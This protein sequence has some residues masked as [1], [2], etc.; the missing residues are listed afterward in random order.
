ML[1]SISHSPR[2]LIGVC[3][4]MA[5]GF[6]SYLLYSLKKGRLLNGISRKPIFRD[7][8]PLCYWFYMFIYLFCDGVAI[9]GFI[10]LSYQFSKGLPLKL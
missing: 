8:D 6:S 10:T 1:D 2:F 3:L 9:Y 5:V 4:A 7:E